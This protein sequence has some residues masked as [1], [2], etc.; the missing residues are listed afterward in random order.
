[1]HCNELHSGFLNIKISLH[2]Q[3]PDSDVTYDQVWIEFLLCI[4]PSKVNTHT[5]TLLKTV[6]F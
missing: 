4:N 1:M 2:P 5:Y 3:I 6:F